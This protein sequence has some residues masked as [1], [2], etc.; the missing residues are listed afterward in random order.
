MEKLYSENGIVSLREFQFSS[1]RDGWVWIE[2]KAAGICRTDLYV[3]EGQLGESEIVPGHEFSGVIAEGNGDWSKGE[4]VVVNPILSSE[5]MLGVDE[6]GCFANFVEVP[7]SSLYKLPENLSYI[8]G[9]YAEPVAACLGVLNS[10]ISKEQ[11]GVILGE[12]GLLI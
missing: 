11:R 4:R 9:A 5:R 1:R 3:M 8:Y 6:D 7:S 2:V 12:V 10:G